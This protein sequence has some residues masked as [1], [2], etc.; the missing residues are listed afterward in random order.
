MSKISPFDY[1]KAINNKR[2]IPEN[3]DGYQPSII[4]HALSAFQDTVLL[5]NEMNCNNQLPE[6]L[7]FDFYYHGVRQRNRF[8]KWLKQ[9]KNDDLEA[10]CKFYGYSK[11]KGKQVLRILTK[12][13]LKFIHDSFDV[14]GV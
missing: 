13:Q 4:N 10:V 5:A 3:L 11:E 1:I 8:E 6:Q 2:N 7:Q 12:E 14:G 9:D